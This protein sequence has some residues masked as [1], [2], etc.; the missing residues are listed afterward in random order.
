MNDL[1]KALRRI[2]LAQEGV[3]EG[4]ACEGTSLESRTFGVKKKNFLFVGSKDIR[5]KLK[6]RGWVKIA[7]GDDVPSLATL[8]E[9]IA[10]SRALVTGPAPRPPKR[11]TTGARR[12]GSS[13]PNR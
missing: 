7:R 12:T 8:E 2:A 1:D 10:E 5:L 6:K 9:W 4:V 13:R 11:S 3:E